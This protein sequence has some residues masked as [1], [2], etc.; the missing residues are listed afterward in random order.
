MTMAKIMTLNT[1]SWMEEEPQKKLEQLIE[2]I[3]LAD[4]D[5]I[6]LQEVNQLLESEVV[7]PDSYFQPLTDQYPIH[8]DNFALILVKELSKK[9]LNYYWSWATSHIGYDRYAEGAAILSKNSIQATSFLASIE[10]DFTDYH[11]RQ[12]LLGKTEFLGQE[13]RVLSGHYSWWTSERNSGFAYEW[14]QTLATLTQ[15]NSPIILMGD[16]NNAADVKGEGYDYVLETAPHLIDTYT[17]AEK[18]H[19]RYTVEKSIDGWQG[20]QQQLRIDY[21]FVT[22]PFKV[23]RHQVIFDGISSPIVSD[24]Y[25]IEAEITR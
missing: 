7:T 12:I 9:G 22:A 13:V 5:I 16:L 17:V 23:A 14:K 19:G 8:Q 4:Y 3:V 21:I 1:H 2:Q 11:T 6:A 15:E 10:N 24:H 25:G 18:T 20:N